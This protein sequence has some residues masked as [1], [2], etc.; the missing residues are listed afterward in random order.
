MNDRDTRDT[1]IDHEAIVAEVRNRY[2]RIA[3]S[4]GSCCGGGDCSTST[5]LAADLG[6]AESELQLLPNGADLGLGCGAPVAL[7]DPQPGEVILDLGSGAGID[8]LI[9][10]RAVGPT[11][12]VLGVDMTD[13]MLDRA[14]SNAA[15]AGIDHVEFRKGRL[16]DLPVETASV[17]GVTSNCVINLVPD[18][19]AVFREVARVLRP[20]GRLVVSDIVLDADLP[21]AVAGD[22]LA[23]VGCVAGAMRRGRYFGLLSG[24]GLRDVEIL[25][26]VDYLA[27]ASTSL[28]PDLRR[29]VDASGVDAA[30][31]EGTVRSVTYRAWKR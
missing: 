18:K 3:S 5:A 27:I 12:R 19:A 2:G 6:Y 9:A 16:E 28:P 4:G 15:G 25:K 11:G 23:W 13:E 10:A 8:V 1:T 14:R 21:D 30:S 17:D 26:D 20:G 24:A 22:L 7:L 29:V 31:L